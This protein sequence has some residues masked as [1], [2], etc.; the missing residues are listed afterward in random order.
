[1]ASILSFGIFIMSTPL[2]IGLGRPSPVVRLISFLRNYQPFS[3]RSSITA[4]CSYVIRLCAL[5]NS[6]KP[7]HV[8]I[9]LIC[10]PIPL[11]IKQVCDQFLIKPLTNDPAGFLPATQYGG[12][13]FVATKFATTFSF[14]GIPQWETMFGLDKCNGNAQPMHIG[15]GAIV[16]PFAM[17]QNLP[18]ISFRQETR[19]GA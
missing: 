17:A 3:Q 18:I 11:Q 13:Y 12:I 7:N 16:V 4:S 14:K 6:H 15:D 8:C 1:M 19:N 9:Y 2:K 10:I 5:F